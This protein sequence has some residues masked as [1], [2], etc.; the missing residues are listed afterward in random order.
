MDENPQSPEG[1]AQGG[2]PQAQAS[3]GQATQPWYETVT[4]QDWQSFL[5]TEKGQAVRSR[6]VQSDVDKALTSLRSGRNVRE[7][8]TKLGELLDEY[9]TRVRAA[10]D[11]EQQRVR[12]EIEERQFWDAVKTAT[13]EQKAEYLDQLARDNEAQQVIGP[14]AQALTERY[15]GNVA[16][17]ILDKLPEDQ[18]T[19]AYDEV[20]RTHQATGNAADAIR[21]LAERYAKTMADQQ[22]GKAL[23][24]IKT[25]DLPAMVQAALREHTAGAIKG[26][27][28]PD[29]T[30]SASPGAADDAELDAI[31]DSPTATVDQKR[32]AF[33]ARYGEKLA[34]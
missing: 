4:D 10:S 6:M 7:V 26:A 21:V 28:A 31:L 12:V 20:V 30:P 19:S 32:K 5:E 11:V 34:I 9:G 29:L 16:R 2:E 13:P 22:L 8:N 24:D 27:P 15:F 23:D 14:Q 17:A 33:E 18:R 25:K 3:G 1:A